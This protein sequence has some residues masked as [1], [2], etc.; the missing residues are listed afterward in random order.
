MAKKKSQQIDREL[1]EESVRKSR[2]RNMLLLV[3]GPADS[4][5]STFLKQMRLLH[6]NGSSIDKAPDDTG[7]LNR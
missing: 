7:F 5:K 3:L 4:G 1:M 2:Q 6:G